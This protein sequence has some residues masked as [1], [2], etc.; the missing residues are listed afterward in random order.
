MTP[1]SLLDQVSTFSAA[2]FPYKAFNFAADT[3]AME[4][5]EFVQKVMPLMLAA[6]AYHRHS[7]EGLEHV[8][9]KGRALIVVNHSLATYD[10]MLLLTA[11]QQEKGR[12]PR[13]L[14]DRLFFKIPY[15]GDLATL[16]GAVEGSQKAAERLLNED[17]LIT[18]APG[19]MREALRPSTQR[20][21]IRWNRRTGFVKLAMRTRSPIILAACPKAD[22]LYDVYPSHVTAWI[23]KN[24]K[25]PVFF[26][27]GLGPTP[28]PRPIQ[29]T[30]F[31]SEPMLPP[32]PTGDEDHDDEVARKFHEGLMRRMRDLISAGVHHRS[33]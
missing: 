5:E 20:Y 27:R 18:V 30:H 25:V 28:I 29:L 6:R 16:Y 15:L 14:I 8:P 32:A 24:F 7:V 4:R 33:N 26:A 19:G 3:L 17:E 1:S 21:Q 11:I 2:S 9:N 12:Q 31:L 23:Y 10:I 22:D 13:P